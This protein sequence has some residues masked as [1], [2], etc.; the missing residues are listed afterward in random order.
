MC[1]CADYWSEDD[2]Q[3]A[4]QGDEGQPM[5][6]TDQ[7]DYDVTN[8][9]INDEIRIQKIKTIGQQIVEGLQEFAE[10]LKNDECITNRDYTDINNT[11]SQS[12]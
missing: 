1:M 9:I 6:I 11:T 5:S 8:R 3:R 2:E 4:L 7:R 10:A 12:T